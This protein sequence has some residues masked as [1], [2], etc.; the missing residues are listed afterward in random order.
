MPFIF[1]YLFS[2]STLALESSKTLLL[3]SKFIYFFIV[4][5]TYSLSSETHII[6]SSFV[7]SLALI[8]I[9]FLIA[10]IESV[11]NSIFLLN[12]LESSISLGIP[13][14]FLSISFSLLISY[15][16]SLPKLALSPCS[17]EHNVT[18]IKISF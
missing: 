5:I 10:I 12:G 11:V 15:S 4:L 2:A 6:K 13:K 3:F 16:K 8:L 9:V 14:L 18:A 17:S 7:F 1:K